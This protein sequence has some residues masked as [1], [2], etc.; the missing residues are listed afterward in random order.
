MDGPGSLGVGVGVGVCPPSGA[1]SNQSMF[2]PSPQNRSTTVCVPPSRWAGGFATSLPVSF[3]TTVAVSPG[4]GK[5]P[6]VVVNASNEP[7][8]G[9]RTENP[10]APS[11]WT[12]TY[13]PA[14][15]LAT[16]S[17]G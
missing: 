17:E 7:V 6:L 9:T 15:G 11:I 12:S 13:R 2:W 1:S 10:I 5:T 8:L 16:R 4:E 14:F 3:G